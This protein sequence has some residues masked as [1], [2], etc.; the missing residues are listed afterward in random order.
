MAIS[1]INFNSR[2][3]VTTPAFLV[4]PTS[5]Q[6]NI[7]LNTAVTVVF[8][9]E[10]FDNNGDFASNTFTAPVAGRY[11]LSMLIGLS[12]LDLGHTFS[13]ANLV[14]SNR[15]YLYTIDNAADFSADFSENPYSCTLSI[16]ADMDASDTAYVAVQCQGGTQQTDIYVGSF[17]SGHLVA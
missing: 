16:L 1:K 9:T 2:E 15:T 6:S 17:F 7:A 10:V 5:T 12:E 8:G 13:G 11:Q 4:K 3:L 14:T